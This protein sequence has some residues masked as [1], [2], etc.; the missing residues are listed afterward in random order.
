MCPDQSNRHSSGFRHIGDVAA[1]IVERVERVERETEADLHRAVADFLALALP[2][3]VVWTTFPA[4][5]G[6]KV[7]GA[8][9]KRAGL[10]PG[11]PDILLVVPPRGRLVGIELKLKGRKPSKVQARVHEQL[12][13]AGAV[14][15]TCRSLEGVQ[16]FLEQL[17][18]LRVRVS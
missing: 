1:G 8:S 3:N 10:K 16:H 5:G 13:L 2:E 4:G 12:T 9:L 17:I 18:P 6:G 14:V 7:R 11:W 15:T